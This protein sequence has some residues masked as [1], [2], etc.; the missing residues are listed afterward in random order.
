MK[1]WQKV[2]IVAGSGAVVWGL[3]YLSSVKPEMAM[4]FASINTAVVAVCSFFTGYPASERN[5]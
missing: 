3:S 1:T 4:M 5:P 2:L